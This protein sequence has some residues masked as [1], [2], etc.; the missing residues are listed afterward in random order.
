MPDL[1]GAYAD[2]RRSMIEIARGL[3]EEE[4]AATVP[5]CPAWTVK[6]LIAHVTSIASTLATGRFPAGLD[7]VASLTDVEQAEQ[8]E[9]F[10]ED[11]LAA[12]KD[13]PLD[14]ILKEWEE[15]SPSVEAMIR[16]ELPWPAASPPLV[17]WV[18]TTDLGVHHHDLRGAVNQP[19]DRD[20]L[21][22]GLSLR[23]YA[24]GMRFRS[25]ALGLP[26][27]RIRAGTREWLIGHGDPVA[28]VTADP[29]E[30]ARAASGRRAPEQIRAFDW[31]GDPD[32]FVPLF[33]PYGA[34]AE[35]LV[36]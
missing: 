36:E 8:R 16:G 4:C 2:T 15:A 30:L 20:S 26:A 29:F 27:F 13:T 6:D 12:R 31:D 24:E 32:P 25:A 14:E 11:A 7:P 34:R 33:Y 35:G 9:R 17:E 28:T 1:A 18:V 22:T 21:A 19:G 5:A 10:V 23:S 3:T